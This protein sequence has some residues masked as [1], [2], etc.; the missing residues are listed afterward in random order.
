VPLNDEDIAELNQL[1]PK[2]ENTVKKGSHEHCDDL[3][4]AKRASRIK[5]RLG[6]RNS[7]QLGFRIK[8]KV[9]DASKRRSDLKNK[10]QGL[11]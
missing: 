3:H 4:F 7:W 9:W 5:F 1:N 10:V 11:G 2:S 8:R 6:L